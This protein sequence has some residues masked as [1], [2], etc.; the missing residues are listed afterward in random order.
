VGQRIRRAAA[1]TLAVAWAELNYEG[2]LATDVGDQLAHHMR[3]RHANCKRA[4]P[5]EKL[6]PATQDARP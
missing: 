6:V 1:Q 4:K 5:K 2:R 3:R